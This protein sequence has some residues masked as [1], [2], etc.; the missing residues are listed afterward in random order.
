MLNLNR[1][2]NRFLIIITILLISNNFTLA[3]N[4]NTIEKNKFN[5]IPTVENGKTW[6]VDDNANFPFLGTEKHPFSSINEAI[7][8]ANDDDQLYIYNGTY[9]ENIVIN[10]GITL[11]GESNEN[12]IIKNVGYAHTISLNVD[13]IA[14]MNLNITNK[15]APHTAI[16]IISNNNM[17]IK[18]QISHCEN[19]GIIIFQSMNNYIHK[20]TISFNGNNGILVEY[21]S[22]NIISENN[23]TSNKRDAINIHNSMNDEINNNKISNNQNEGIYI[24]N[25]VNMTITDNDCYE[26]GIFI[27]GGNINYWDTH[28]ISNNSANG[29]K[30]LYYKNVDDISINSNSDAANVIFAN[31]TNC[32][33]YDLNLSH[34]GS[35][36]QLG[37]SKNI[38]IFNNTLTENNIEGIEICNS[39]FITIKNNII[40]NNN[41]NGIYIHYHSNDNS[42]I[43]NTIFNNSFDGIEIRDFSKRNNILKNLIWNNIRKGIE[44]TRSDYIVID[45]N[46]IYDSIQGVHLRDSCNA[47]ITNNTFESNGIRIE[48]NNINYWN[49][50]MIFNN[51]CDRKIIRYFKNLNDVFIPSKTLQIIFANC[52]NSI[53]NNRIISNVDIGI[54]LGFSS[55]NQIIDND[56]S[57]NN[58]NGIYLSNSK[59]NLVENNI[60]SDNK[61]IGIDLF[62]S[63]SNEIIFNDISKNN[64]HGLRIRDSINTLIN[65]NIFR[66]NRYQGIHTDD[67]FN[68]VIS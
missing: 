25:S 13:D 40:S 8:I 51:T 67:S 68:N 9:H 36:I 39:S 42:V 59:N 43:N 5:D 32:S 45:K 49:S 11:Y 26:N 6:Y 15:N 34:V 28:N 17:I 50:H 27:R 23:L 20:N 57:H 33:I 3:L 38:C 52:S 24:Q 37:F 22:S 7:S 16:N 14:I 30:I 46:E 12:T 61:Y 63:E 4:D 31:C 21:S 29:K 66:E 41:E 65:N 47:M 35:A 58:L 18:N 48:G 55:N 19:Y 56:L 62:E 53:I 64:N 2:L 44:I 1:H 10:K 54:Q 60:I